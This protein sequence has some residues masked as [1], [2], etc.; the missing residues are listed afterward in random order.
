MN[1]SYETILA[2]RSV[3]DVTDT[4][5]YRLKMLENLQRL[6]AERHSVEDAKAQVPAP[7]L[8]DSRLS[9]AATKVGLWQMAGLRLCRSRDSSGTN[10]RHPLVRVSR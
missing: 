3:N 6:D 1:D 2:D 8:N 9:G 4:L 10:S 5:H 7:R